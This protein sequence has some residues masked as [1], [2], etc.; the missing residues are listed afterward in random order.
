VIV[1]QVI[2]VPEKKSEKVPGPKEKKPGEEQSARVTVNLPSDARLWVDAVECPLTS[3][4]RSFNTPALNPGQRY[5]Y[6]LKVEIVRDGRTVSETQR[7]VLTPG[8]ETRVDFSNN[9]GAIATAIASQGATT[10]AS[11]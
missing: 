4:V 7:I 10:T 3:S 8:E 2:Q 5:A 11:R 6:S 9:G 1:P